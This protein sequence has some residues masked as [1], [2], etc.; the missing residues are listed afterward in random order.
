MLPL[1]DDNPTHIRPLVT[2]AIIGLCIL[3]YGWQSAGTTYEYFRV[4]H[5]FGVVPSSLIGNLPVRTD[6]V[7]VPAALTLIT[8]MFLHGGF[9]HLAGNVLYLWMFGNS[10]EAAMGHTR[11][12]LFYLLCGAVAAGC[13]AGVNPHSQIPMVGAS[14]AISG[15]LGAYLLLYPSARVL[16][17]LPLGR[18]LRPVHLP[19]AWVLLFWFGFQVVASIVAAGKEGGI[20]WFAHVG[21]F[22]AGMAFVALFTRSGVQ[23]FNRTR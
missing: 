1:T 20:A 18:Y 11:F 12:T 15:V 7:P 6:L 17:I 2:V 9:M 22:L 3:T 13:H 10:I 16:V 21:G 5:S 4:I 23:L 8:S 19:A 14:G